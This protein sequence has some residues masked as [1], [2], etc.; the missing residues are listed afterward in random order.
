MGKNLNYALN[1]DV[2]DR[3][4]SIKAI[5][6]AVWGAR[7]W[8]TLSLPALL[9]SCRLDIRENP[10]VTKFF[11]EEIFKQGVF[12]NSI[13]QG[14]QYNQDMFTSAPTAILKTERGRLD[15][16]LW[17]CEIKNALTMQKRVPNMQMKAHNKNARVYGADLLYKDHM[18]G[19]VYA[20]DSYLM[21]TPTVWPKEGNKFSIQTPDMVSA[22]G[23]DPN[24]SSDTAGGD[25]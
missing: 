24:S 12:E 10:L 19:Q 5:G 8:L 25:L 3:R 13:K 17:N 18:L 21:T 9:Y 14:F 4:T 16:N 1:A 7:K 15:S 22:G 11:E 6:E 23:G 2:L 20:F